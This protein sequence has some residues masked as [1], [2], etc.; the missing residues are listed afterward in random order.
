MSH[1]TNQCDAE[2]E[3]NSRSMRKLV[4]KACDRGLSDADQAQLEHLLEES[5]QVIDDYAKF[6]VGEALVEVACSKTYIDSEDLPTS[7]TANLG[8]ATGQRA[9]ELAIA[10][11]S[12]ANKTEV[13]KSQLN[14]LSQQSTATPGPVVTSVAARELPKLPL[15]KWRDATVRWTPYAVSA[16]LLLSVTLWWTNRPGAHLVADQD[17]R[18]ADGVARDV[19]EAFGADWVV[20]EEGEVQLAFRSGAMASIRGPARFR[21]DSGSEGTLDHGLLSAHVP[22]GAHG[23]A[24]H[25]PFA[26]VIDRGTGFRLNVQPTGEALLHVTEGLVDFQSQ[27]GT[28]RLSMKAGQR[29]S[30]DASQT[31]SLQKAIKVRSTSNVKFVESHPRSLAYNAYDVD[32]QIS[33]FLEN[34]SVTLDKE[35]RLNAVATGKHNN[36]EQTAGKLTPEEAA[37]SS[38]ISCYL[39]HCAPQRLRHIVEGRITFPGKII[40][41]IGNSD[42][43][44]ATNALLGTPWTLA[45]NHIERG[46]ESAPDRNSDLVTI[47]KDRRTLSVIMRT[48]SIDQLRVLVAN[49]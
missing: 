38:P 3:S 46:I 19:G 33:V 34:P 13:A 25:T 10:D 31:I 15:A 41:V 8:P 21:V 36:F 11:L 9:V 32:D 35:L 37:S 47:S 14:S 17:A 6:V 26:E 39:L 4:S 20:L 18:W 7:P 45:C 48:E 49:E 27:N 2:R 22:E 24:I 29:A 5:P 40:G 42:A 43:L 1:P 44:N 30:I 12:S 28:D 16:I 23:F